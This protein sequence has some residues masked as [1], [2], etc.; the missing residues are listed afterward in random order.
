VWAPGLGDLLDPGRQRK[1][2]QD[3]SAFDGPP[4]AKVADGQDVGALEMEHQEHVGAPEADALDGRQLGDHL[5]VFQGVEALQLEFP[6]DDVLGQRAKE[7]DL[8]PRET[9]RGPQG[10][11][12]VVQDLLRR[13]G[14]AREAFG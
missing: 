3:V 10:R 14:T 12:I 4:D 2:L 1:L 9:R 6:A 5:V 13:R 7:A 11:G 8:G